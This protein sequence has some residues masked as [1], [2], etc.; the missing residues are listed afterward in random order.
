MVAMVVLETTV[1]VLML[2]MLPQHIAQVVVA[3]AVAPRV[4][5]LIEA[6]QMALLEPE[7][8]LIRL[9]QLALM[10]LVQ[11]AKVVEVMGVVLDFPLVIQVVLDLLELRVQSR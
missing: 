10:A 4:D 7:G 6:A 1:E 5:A 8:F 3:A 9:E 11:Q 2:S